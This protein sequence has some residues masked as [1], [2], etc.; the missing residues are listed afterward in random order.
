MKA[1]QKTYEGPGSSRLFL[2]TSLGSL[3]YPPLPSPRPIR[4]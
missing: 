4:D 3:G 2:E 1:A